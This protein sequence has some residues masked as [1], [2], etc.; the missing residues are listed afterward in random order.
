MNIDSYSEKREL[1]LIRSWDSG[2][3]YLFEY[4]KGR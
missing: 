2:W 4:I 3:E 1:D